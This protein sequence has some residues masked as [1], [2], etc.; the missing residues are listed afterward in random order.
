[1]IWKYTV[2]WNRCSFPAF[3]VASIEFIVS[4]CAGRAVGANSAGDV[5][6]TWRC[7]VCSKLRSFERWKSLYLLQ[8]ALVYPMPFPAIRNF[9]R[10]RAGE[11]TVTV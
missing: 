8:I 11:D 6:R 3:F 4:R 10:R 9:N 2:S 5:R 1:M 7:A